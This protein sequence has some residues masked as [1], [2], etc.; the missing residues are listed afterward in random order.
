MIF[1]VT[2]VHLADRHLRWSAFLRHL[3]AA[4]ATYAVTLLFLMVVPFVAQG[5]LLFAQAL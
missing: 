5:H 4:D 2:P 3:Q 1:E